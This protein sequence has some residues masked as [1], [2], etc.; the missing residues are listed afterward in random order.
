[1]NVIKTWGELRKAQREMLVYAALA[2]LTSVLFFYQGGVETGIVLALFASLF[3]GMGIFPRT[4]KDIPVVRRWII[5]F[6]LVM[7]GFIS[8]LQYLA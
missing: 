5:G 1:M 7:F 4:S 2:T 6:T 8:V 3:A